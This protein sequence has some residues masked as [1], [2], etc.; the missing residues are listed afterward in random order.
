M[1]RNNINVNSEIDPHI[2][3]DWRDEALGLDKDP[4]PHVRMI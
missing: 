2:K 1:K 3:E 4:I